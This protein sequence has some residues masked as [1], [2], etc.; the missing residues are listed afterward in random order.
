[1]QIKHLM[2]SNAVTVNEN[3]TLAEVVH[4]LAESGAS[5]IPVVDSEGALQGIVTEH[6][7]IKTVMPSLELVKTDDSSRINFD[8]FLA[9]RVRQ[10]KDKPV[11]SIMTRNVMA[12]SEDDSL[13]KATSAML[14]KKLKVLPVVCDGRVAGMVSRTD[15]ARAL[16]QTQTDMDVEAA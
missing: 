9:M 12:L 7:V 10:V 8:F 3:A 2:N 5:G 16:L 1:M 4:A 15:I 6:D 14:M 11:S 13:M